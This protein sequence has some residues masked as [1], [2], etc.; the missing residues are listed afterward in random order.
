MCFDAMEFDFNVFRNE[1]RR[2]I[3]NED[4]STRSSVDTVCDKVG[5]VN[6]TAKL[7]K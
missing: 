5:V 4:D 7:H 1:S 3:E 2:R 6:D